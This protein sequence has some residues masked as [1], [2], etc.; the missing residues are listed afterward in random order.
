MD[1]LE[2]KHLS[3]LNS[4]A[5][6][7]SVRALVLYYYNVFRKKKKKYLKTKQKL[8]AHYTAAEK[9]IDYFLLFTYMYIFFFL[10]ECVI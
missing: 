7:I 10:Y 1:Q 5:E 3:S 8:F 2:F 4:F 9:N 6:R